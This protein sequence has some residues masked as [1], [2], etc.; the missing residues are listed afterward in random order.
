MEAFYRAADLVGA[1]ANHGE[2]LWWSEKARGVLAA[3]VHAA[4][5]PSAEAV[6]RRPGA[7]ARASRPPAW[8]APT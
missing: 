7:S 8:P 5:L 1:V 3:A 2:M 4:G 6:A